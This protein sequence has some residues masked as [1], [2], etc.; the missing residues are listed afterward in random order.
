MPRVNLTKNKLNKIDFYPFK[1]NSAKLAMT[2]HILYKKLD[3]KNVATFSK[4][5]I[6][7]IIRKKMGFKGILISDD[8]SMKALKFD[9]ITVSLRIEHDKASIIKLFP[10]KYC[11]LYCLQIK[12][13]KKFIIHLIIF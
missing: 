12:N 1:S 2:A 7:Q 11:S 8:V 3:A 9:L 6:L 10:F 4:K 5:V 13:Y